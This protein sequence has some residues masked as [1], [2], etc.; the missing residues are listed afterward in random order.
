MRSAGLASLALVL[1][2]ACG[3]PQYTHWES[4]KYPSPMSAEHLA[5]FNRDNYECQRENTYQS[6]YVNRY[7]GSSGQEVNYDLALACMNAR[8]WYPVQK[9]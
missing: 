7:G 9:K 3:G 5:Q 2:T 8:G 4:T 6:T 1:L